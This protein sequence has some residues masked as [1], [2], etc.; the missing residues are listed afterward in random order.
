MNNNTIQMTVV[1]HFRENE[2][3]FLPNSLFKCHIFLY[4]S[5]AIYVN[6]FLQI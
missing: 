6:F 3:L 1:F 4:K 5:K 2:D